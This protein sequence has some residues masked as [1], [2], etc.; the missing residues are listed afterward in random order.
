[1]AATLGDAWAGAREIARRVG[2]D[3]GFPRLSGPMTPPPA[4][5]PRA[6]AVLETA[7]WPGAT[8]GARR[9]LERSVARL[10]S[11]GVAI[12]TRQDTPLLEK[13]ERALAEAMTI[14][15]T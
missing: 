10:R 15:R 1:M 4:K 3:P 12:L 6:L 7:G 9:G 14:T 13:L 2:G 8:D 5:K 11:A